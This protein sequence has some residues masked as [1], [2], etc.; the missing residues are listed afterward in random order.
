MT[1][2]QANTVGDLANL[3]TA[4]AADRET[5]ATLTDTI[6]QLLLELA[7]AQAKLILSLLDNQRLLKRFSEKGG[8]WN[9]SGGVA[10]RKTSGDGAAG[11]WDGPSIH[12]CHTHGHK[13]PLPSFK[14]PDPANGHIKN[15]TKKDTRGVR[16]QDYK[17]K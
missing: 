12:Y 7:S 5:V 11:P 2:H 3:V 15:A 17:N 13:C 1:N 16:Y 8:S 10:D 4:T 14:C 9:T 6:A